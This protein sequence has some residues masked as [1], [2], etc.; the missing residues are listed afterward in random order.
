LVGGVDLSRAPRAA[1]E[2]F[3]SHREPPPKEA[4]PPRRGRSSH[5]EREHAW[6]MMEREREYSIRRW[7]MRLRT[8][9]PGAQQHEVLLR[10]K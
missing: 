10:S 2:D 7:L 1:V 6:M 3:L 4:G 8:H 5:R 9:V